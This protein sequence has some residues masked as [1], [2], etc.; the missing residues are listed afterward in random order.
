MPV[1]LASGDPT[2]STSSRDH[3]YLWT[4][5]DSLLR[6]NRQT[7]VP[8]PGLVT[9]WELPDPLTLVLHL[10]E[11]VTFQDGTPFN[12]DA[13]KFNIERAKADD[14][15]VKSDFAFVATVDAT[16]ALTATLHLSQPD[17][18]LLTAL[19]DKGGMMVSPTEVAK[20]DIGTNPVGTGPWSFESQDPGATFVV[21]K[22]AD[23]WDKETPRVDRIEFRVIGEPATASNAIRSGEVDMVTNVQASEAQALQGEGFNVITSAGLETVILIFNVNKKPL[24]DPKVREAISLAVDREDLVKTIEFDRATPTVA[25]LPS[26]H[27]AYPKNLS[28]PKRDVEKAKALL[29]EAGYPDGVDFEMIAHTTTYDQRRIEEVQAKL[30]EANIRVKITQLDLATNALRFYNDQEFNAMLA[31]FGGRPDPGTA[32]SVLFSSKGFLNPGKFNT[33]GLDDAIAAANA[34]TDQTKRASLLGDVAK[35]ISD[36]YRTVPLYAKPFTAVLADNV[37]GY[38]PSSNGKPIFLGITLSGN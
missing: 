3:Q 35:I 9:K 33:P 36:N 17:A 19:S 4:I 37:V 21:K 22:Y 12:A 26:E 7:L 20:G 18:A 2:K 1:V 30:A 16:D 15:T 11:G 32:Y 27:W 5:Y 10:R 34:E 14:S 25:I 38:V 24:D 31:D 8:E 28:V 13:V 6:F 29:A 23:Y